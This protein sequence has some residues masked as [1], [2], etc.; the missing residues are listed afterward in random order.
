MLFKK[1]SLLGIFQCHDLT[2]LHIFRTDHR[3]QDCNPIS[4]KSEITPSEGG[5][6]LL[7][8]VGQVTVA[9][10]FDR[11]NTFA[12]I[13]QGGLR[14]PTQFIGSK[15]ERIPRILLSFNNYD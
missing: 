13:N 14:I 12:P 3:N 1:K 11:L 9:P 15:H 8:T 7:E 4:E 6:R 10:P 2:I 5:M